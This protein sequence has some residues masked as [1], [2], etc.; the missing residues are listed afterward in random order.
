MTLTGLHQKFLQYCEV[1]GQLAPQTIASYRS[2]FEQ[3]K[4]S[5]RRHER[6][7][8]RGRTR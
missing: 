5:L 3:F 1:E 4:E 7:R 2:D 6:L 8:L